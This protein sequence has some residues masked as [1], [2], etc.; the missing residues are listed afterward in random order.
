MPPEAK[1]IETLI[2]QMIK[3]FNSKDSID[4]PIPIKAGILAYEFV[5]IHPFLGWKW[6]LFK[7]I[8]WKNFTIKI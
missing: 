8:L 5:T 4:I 7:I 3:E 1:D 2:K 6:S